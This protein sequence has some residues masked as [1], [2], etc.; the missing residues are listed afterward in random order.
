MAVGANANWHHSD[1]LDCHQIRGILLTKYPRG[2]SPMG[3]DSRLA[4]G[5]TSRPTPHANES[6]KAGSCSD[7]SLQADD[8]D[9]NTVSQTDDKM[10]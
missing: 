5:Q 8:N 7:Y 1:S 4:Y 10:N 3:W 9:D 6:D 2:F